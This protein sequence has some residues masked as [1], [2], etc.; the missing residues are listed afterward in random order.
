MNTSSDTHPTTRRGYTLIELIVTMGIIL[1][2]IGLIVVNYNNFND[3]QRVRQAASDVKSNLRYAQ[4]KALSAEKPGVGCTRLI[5]YEVSFA[6]TSYQIQPRCTEGLA[7]SPV[8]V[9]LLPGLTVTAAPAVPLT[10]LVLSRGIDIS[11]SVTITIFGVNRSYQLRVSPSGD[12]ND[13]G[14]I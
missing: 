2:V 14:F 5:G 13:L 11:S 10:F 1:V 3:N 7:G 9:S 6:A 4:T 12:I 8:T